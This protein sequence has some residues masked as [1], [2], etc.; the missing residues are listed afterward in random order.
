MGPHVLRRLRLPLLLGLAHAIGAGT[1][2]RSPWGIAM[3]TALTTPIVFALASRML[4]APPRNFARLHPQ[5]QA[6]HI[7]PGSI[8]AEA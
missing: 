1:D 3:L 6:Q 5:P 8:A 4:P 7:P 2:G